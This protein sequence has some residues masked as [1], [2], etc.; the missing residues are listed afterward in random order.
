MK[1]EREK[2][3]PYSITYMWNLKY[4]TNEPIDKTETGSGPREKTCGCQGEATGRD[5]VST[6]LEFADVNSYI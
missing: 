1:S 4:D 6:R 2:Q 3:T 5:G